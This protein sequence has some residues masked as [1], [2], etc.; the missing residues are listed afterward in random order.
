MPETRNYLFGYG[1]RLKEPLEPLRRPMEKFHPYSISEARARLAPRIL[2]AAADIDQ[3]PK[4]ACPR[5]EAVAALT[6]HPSYL[7]KTYFPSDLLRSLHFDPVGSRPRQIRPEKGTKKQMAS[8]G[9][10]NA[11]SPSTTIDLFVRG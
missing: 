3:L 1:E 8:K 6:L 9:K 7:A 5:D 10:G 2:S 4:A 11:R